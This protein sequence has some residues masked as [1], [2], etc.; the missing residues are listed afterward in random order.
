MTSKINISTIFFQISITFRRQC[1]LLCSGTCKY[2]KESKENLLEH[3]GYNHAGAL[4]KHRKMLQEATDEEEN[5]AL[6]SQLCIQ[7]TP[8]GLKTDFHFKSQAEIEKSIAINLCGKGGLPVSIAEQDCFLEFMQDAQPKFKN[9]SY[10]KIF[11]LVDTE[12][13]TRDT[14][15]LQ[16]IRESRVSP[17]VILDCW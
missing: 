7:L 3:L 10:R 13:S 4:E 15:L 8:N 16:Q 6:K 17:S 12:S 1:D 5:R 2:S 9:I 14:K 11:K